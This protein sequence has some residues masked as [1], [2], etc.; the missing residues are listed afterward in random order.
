MVTA[1]L[2][3]KATLEKVATDHSFEVTEF[4]DEPTFYLAVLELCKSG[5]SRE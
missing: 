5:N 4:V 2:P 1:A 3:D